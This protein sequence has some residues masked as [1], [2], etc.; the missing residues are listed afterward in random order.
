VLVGLPATL[1]GDLLA[2]LLGGAASVASN[3]IPTVEAR[4]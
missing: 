3:P 4:T 2:R 1:G